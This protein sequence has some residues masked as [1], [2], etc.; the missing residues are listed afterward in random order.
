M[1]SALGA[2]SGTNAE[3]PAS[4]PARGGRKEEGGKAALALPFKPPEAAVGVR[5]S[6]GDKA[7]RAVG[8]NGEGSGDI[9]AAGGREEGT[10]LLSDKPTAKPEPDG[11]QP[12]LDSVP[13]GLHGS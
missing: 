3:A 4:P 10:I 1:Q 6:S 7:S 13:V 11:E 5:V 8:V 9:S 2:G 12:Q